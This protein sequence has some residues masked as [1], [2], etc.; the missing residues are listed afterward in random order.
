MIKLGFHFFGIDVSV[1][2]STKEDADHLSYYFNDFLKNNITPKIEFKLLTNPYGNFINNLLNSDIEKII[3]YRVK[4]LGEW[5]I[6]DRFRNQSNYPSPIP[7]FTFKPL[8]DQFQIFHAAALKSPINQSILLV[9]NSFSG[10]SLLTLALLKKKWHF[11]SDDIAV[12]SRTNFKLYPFTRPIG[13]R[14]NSIELLP[15][16]KEMPALKY[17]IGYTY[18]S[19][20]G[21]THMIHVHDLFPENDDSPTIV[22]AVYFLEHMNQINN[23]K[24]ETCDSSKGFHYLSKYMML[25]NSSKYKDFDEFLRKNISYYIITYNLNIHH[26]NVVDYISKKINYEK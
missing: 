3:L 21:I 4:K 9:G 12:L 23:L 8:V 6:Y 2:V 25:T 26:M 5:I 20:F 24:I 15:W 14:T 1:Y 19:D 18:Q 22:N 16:L 17:K 7:P 11:L 10:K 13:I